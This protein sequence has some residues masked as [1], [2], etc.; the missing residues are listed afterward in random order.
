[1]QQQDQQTLDTGSIQ[2]PLQPLQQQAPQQPTSSTLNNEINLS[3]DGIKMEN[4]NI[5]D[6]VQI[7]SIL[8][9][10]INSNDNNTNNSTTT[11][12]AA[13]ATTDST[14][15]GAASIQDK[16]KVVQQRLML[17]LHAENCVNGRSGTDA[18]RPACK[19]IDC[20]LIKEVMVHLA[21]CTEGRAC[22]RPHCLSSRMLI[23]HWKNCINFYCPVC[24]LR[25]TMSNASKNNNNHV[26]QQ[27]L[28]L[29]NDMLN[30]Q[31]TQQQQSQQQ[32]QPSFSDNNINM[33]NQSV[34]NIATQLA[35][36]V[37]SNS[38]QLG[39]AAATANTG[40]LSQQTQLRQPKVSKVWHGNMNAE[41]RVHLILKIVA[42]IIPPTQSFTDPQ[43]AKVATY[44][45]RTEYDMYEQA[46]SEEQYLHLLAE[47]T[48]KTQ[49]EFEDKQR[50]AK[51]KQASEDY[52]FL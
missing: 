8:Q 42:I 45:V 25:G 5:N 22:T 2:Q 36:V 16:N 3:I 47:Q 39:E 12:A 31:P 27:P 37:S 44:A 46:E 29:S 13:T 38:N 49:K 14:S 23:A 30:N 50:E 11:A 33:I 4:L 15:E 1:M 21:L 32:Q 19:M 7:K 40:I 51:A 35:A 17:L 18:N 34:K 6:S 28:Q 41:I 20:T 48:Y 52:V 24:T 9:P 10:S 26:T 43:L